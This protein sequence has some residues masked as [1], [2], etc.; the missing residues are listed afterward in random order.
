MILLNDLGYV[1]TKTQNIKMGLYQCKCGKEIEA[2]QTRVKNNRVKSC[3]CLKIEKARELTTKRNLVHGLSKT[4]QYKIWKDMKARCYNENNKSFMDYGGRGITICD[5]WINDYEAFYNWAISNSWESGLTIDRIDVD[6]NY[7]PSNCR[8]T[9]NFTQ[10]K[11]RRPQYNK[12]GLT[13]VALVDGKYTSTITY[14]KEK[15]YLG[16][17]DTKEQAYNARLEFIEKNNT[18][19]RQ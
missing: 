4:P 2:A 19:H 14:N 8:W 13:G 7:E 10:A 1:R 9:D 11:N 16:Y 17:F 18:G 12:N 6:G 3:G 5:E 15:I